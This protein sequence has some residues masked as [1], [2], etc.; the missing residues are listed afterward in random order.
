MKPN[1]LMP[2]MNFMTRYYHSSQY[3]HRINSVPKNLYNLF[4]LSI[5]LLAVI[6]VTS[7]EQ[8]PTT[9]GEGNLPG[10]DFVSINAI[11]TMSV[12]S[13]TLY[14]KS[15]PTDNLA[16]SYLGQL[17]DSYFGTTTA[18]FATQIR[19][20][21]EWVDQHYI[22]DS[23]ELV[24]TLLDVKGASDAPQVLRLSEIAE[25][26]YTD[27]MYY[28]DKVVPLT[29]YVIG[30]IPLPALT[31]DTTNIVIVKLGYFV[32]KVSYKGSFKIILQ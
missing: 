21:S 16:T 28:S 23:V 17:Y 10:S 26:L 7:C 9:I 12:T 20:S 5:I 2:I 1:I 25:Q 31:S 11:D 6:F 14:D 19:L 29:G 3:P 32:W 13:Y 30:D 18:E 27:S 8:V 24:L 15:V 4:K 22:I